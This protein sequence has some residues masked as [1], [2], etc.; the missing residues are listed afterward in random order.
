MQAVFRQNSSP[1]SNALGCNF[2][3]IGLHAPCKNDDACGA[4]LSSVFHGDHEI[5]IDARLAYGQM[6]RAIAQIAAQSHSKALVDLGINY[7]GGNRAAFAQPVA[8]RVAVQEEGQQHI[9][10]RVTLQSIVPSYHPLVLTVPAEQ[11]FQA[12]KPLWVSEKDLPLIS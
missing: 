11:A 8:Q 7:G 6:L 1:K 2:V 4:G 5:C 12:R 3:Q 10:R 9:E